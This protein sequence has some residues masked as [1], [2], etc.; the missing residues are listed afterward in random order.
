M[1]AQAIKELVLFLPASLGLMALAWAT[2]GLR[3]RVENGIRTVRPT[4]VGAAIG[5]CSMRLLRAIQHENSW[6]YKQFDSE[7]DVDETLAAIEMRFTPGANADEAD[8]RLAALNEEA[9]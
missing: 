5:R 7:S 6:V 9:A 3:T 8:E 2:G 4:R 1:I